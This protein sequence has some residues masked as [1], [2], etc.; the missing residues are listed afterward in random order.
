MADT[1]TKEAVPSRR[2][3]LKIGA[4]FVA[5]A[6]VASVVEI[7]YYSSIIGGNSSNSSS[8]VADLTD[9]LSTTQSQLSA[10]QSQLSDTQSSLSAAQG[11]ITS[12]NSQLSSSSAALNSA[13]SQV[14]SLNSQLTSTQAALNSANSQVT[15]LN[16]QVTSA[17]AQATGL[18]TQLDENTAFLIL[19]TTEAP[20]VAAIASAFIPTDSTGPGATEAGVVYFIDRALAGE[21][22]SNGNMFMTGPYVTPG[23]AG[24]V[25]VGSITYSGGSPAVRLGAGT[26]FQYPLRM[27]QYWKI[28]LEAFE[29]YCN[30]AYGGNFETLSSANQV[31]AL[32]DLWNNKPTN[33]TYSDPAFKSGV[34]VTEPLHIIPQDFFYELWMLCW[35]G[36]M[37]DPAY[38]GNQNMVSWKIAGFNG[39]N[40]GNF[41]GEGYTTKELMVMTTP[42]QLQPASLGQYQKGSA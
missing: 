9:Q 5:G 31:A 1:G 37:M 2:N 27:R 20:L 28:G 24:P 29:S 33:F 25:T 23:T 10:T 22:G 39:T 6:A 8:T 15:S 4:G 16:G 34:T 32:T 14:T 41:Y 40:Q 19:S 26:R 36:F 35:S 30:T 11:T 21:Y 42:V 3:F 12:L 13:N 17:Q 38:G 18:Q 7:P